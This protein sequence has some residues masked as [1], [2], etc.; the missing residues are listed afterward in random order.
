MKFG[1]SDEVIES[2]R[3]VFRQHMNIEKVLIFGSRAKGC[4]REGSDIDLALIGKDIT[5]RQML[6]LSNAIDDIDLL[7]KID[8]IDYEKAQSTPIGEHIRRVGQL[9]YA[10]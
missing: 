1:L 6:D 8:L 7:Y 5:L 3:N 2:L 10:A 4:Y 9:F